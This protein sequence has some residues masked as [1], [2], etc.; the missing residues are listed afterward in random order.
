MSIAEDKIWN[1]KQQ[2][3]GRLQVKITQKLRYG[4]ASKFPWYAY[5]VVDGQEYESD[6]FIVKCKAFGEIIF[7]LQQNM[8]DFFVMLYY[9][10]SPSHAV[11][12]TM[13]PFFVLPVVVNPFTYYVKKL[14]TVVESENSGQLK[15]L[16]NA[17][18]VLHVPNVNMVVIGSGGPDYTRSGA[19]YLHLAPILKGTI[20]L[21]DPYEV[22]Q[23]IVQ[24]QAT[25]HYRG[26][27]FDYKGDPDKTVTHV[28]DDSFD[29]VPVTDQKDEETVV[30]GVSDITDLYNGPFVVVRGYQS[31]FLL[32]CASHSSMKDKKP[33]GGG[34][35]YS[36]NGVVTLYGSSNNFGPY[37]ATL[38][39][40]LFPK[41]VIKDPTVFSAQGKM[42]ALQKLFPSAIISTKFLSRQVKEQHT[43]I[44]DQKFYDGTEKREY[45]RVRVPK[46]TKMGHCRICEL[47]SSS[48]LR[49]KTTVDDLRRILV[50]VGGYSCFVRP[51]LKKTHMV[52]EILVMAKTATE[53]EEIASVLSSKYHVMPHIV[54]EAVT[55]LMMLGKVQKVK[56]GFRERVILPHACL[57]DK[58]SLALKD[59]DLKIWRKVCNEYNI[60]L[61]V[62][63]VNQRMSEGNNVMY[64]GSEYHPDA[65]VV[66]LTG[67]N[68]RVCARYENTHDVVRKYEKLFFIHKSINPHPI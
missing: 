31:V 2:V 9:E 14:L 15:L 48:A 11:K 7:D 30:Y 37:N 23:K 61:I 53:I 38:L 10:N 33:I 5:W 49:L 46:H 54:K 55:T 58:V 1:L 29:V 35:I 8:V 43:E 51:S 20:T 67:Q 50:L 22:S 64:I 25:M 42:A 6:G 19:T 52:G 45:Y 39:R 36:T 24:E 21:Y 68:V 60:S 62:G 56:Y 28:I 65:L 63:S 26:E 4:V 12:C 32:K 13:D 57:D 18:E 16:C 3:F 47:V 59:K 44:V 27:L 34:R 41:Y 17:L 66:H 40:R